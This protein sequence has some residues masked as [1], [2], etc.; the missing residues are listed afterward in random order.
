MSSLEFNLN[1]TSWLK[2]IVSEG[3]AGP[4]ISVFGLHELL[5]HHAVVAHFAGGDFDGGDGLADRRMA[6]DVIRRRSQP[7][8]SRMIR[9]RR[10]SSSKSRPTWP[11]A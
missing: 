1:A 5:E 8:S 2:W 9:Q 10:T 6:E 3:G 7:I 11:T 4:A